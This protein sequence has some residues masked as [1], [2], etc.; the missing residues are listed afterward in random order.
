MKYF[1][2][3]RTSLA[4]NIKAIRI[5]KG[6]PVD[7]AAIVLNMSR[8]NYYK[9]ESGEQAVKGEWILPLTTLLQVTVE[10][11]FHGRT[12]RK[13]SRLESQIREYL[14]DG[15]EEELNMWLGVISVAFR[16]KITMRQYKLLIDLVA[17]MNE[18][19]GKYE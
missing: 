10:E 11:L 6:I 16:K 19:A 8:A 2:H 7:E 3:Y 4:K 14:Q 15:S 13:I 1:I 9:I 12:G 5:S 17:G 18:I